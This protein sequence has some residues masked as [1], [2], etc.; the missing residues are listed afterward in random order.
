[1][2]GIF[3]FVAGVVLLSGCG[4]SRD[5]STGNGAGPPPRPPGVN[6]MQASDWQ[7][8]VGELGRET[9]LADQ[10]GAWVRSAEWKSRA[11]GV[12]AADLIGEAEQDPPIG[13]RCGDFQTGCVFEWRKWE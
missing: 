3:S 10:L 8:L 13:I 4:D 2:R 11:T 12:P 9:G 7:A 1:M 5:G 6:R